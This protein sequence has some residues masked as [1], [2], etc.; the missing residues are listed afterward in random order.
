[1][2]F[3]SQKYHT[4]SLLPHRAVFQEESLP[5]FMVIMTSVFSDPAIRAKQSIF[6]MLMNVLR[7]LFV[8]SILLCNTMIQSPE[9]SWFQVEAW[10][11]MLN[12]KLLKTYQNKQHK[13][14]PNLLTSNCN[15]CPPIYIDIPLLEIQTLTYWERNRILHSHKTS[16][17]IQWKVKLG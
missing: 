11:L 8:N 9:Q 2:S 17:I 5:K 15:C 7:L 12:S 13:G 6:G 1:M 14:F 4:F 10:P 3:W 16:I